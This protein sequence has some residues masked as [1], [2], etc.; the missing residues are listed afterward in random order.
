MK[1]VMIVQN[2]IIYLDNAATTK[3]MP[4]VIKAMEPYFSELYGNPSSIHDLGIR[5][6]EA[7]ERSRKLLAKII[8]CEEEEIYFTAGGTESDNFA[9]KQTA[10]CYGYRG[11]HIITTSIEHRAVLN[12]CKY[13]EE[14]GFEVTYLKVNEYGKISLK[15]IERH[16]TNNTILISIMHANNEI[17][18]LQSIGEIGML[19]RRHGVI[20]HTDAVQS[21][22]HEPIDVKQLK[23]D[24]LSASAHKFGG[25]KG[26]GFMYINKS[27]KYTPLLHGGSQEK[28]LRA[29]TGNVPGIVGMATAAE[30]SSKNMDKNN[31]YVRELRDYLVN[32]VIGEIEGVMLN[33]EPKDR[34]A[35][36]ANF[37]FEGVEGEAMLVMLDMK[38]ICVST[39]SACAQG[40][41]SLSHVLKSIGLS[42]EKTRSSIRMTLSEKNT[43]EEVDYTVDAV[44]EIILELRKK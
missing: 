17:G 29:G 36:N 27:L 2:K 31:K 35:G 25:P 39:G 1:G 22:C 20:F 19:A 34:L 43:K 11:N 10:E 33:G 32:R 28:R 14:K 6:K 21:V 18:T 40:G 24:I 15:D 16:I 30:I 41:A 5:S 38:G 44:K 12:S 8:N 3:T 37:L 23:I 13:L 7:V 26:V 9:I 42:E 4:E